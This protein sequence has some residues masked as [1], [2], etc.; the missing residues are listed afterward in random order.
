MGVIIRV[1]L[2]ATSLV[3][4]MLVQKYRNLARSLPAPPLSVTE[5]WGPGSAD[6]Y[7]EDPTVRPFD[8]KVDPEL[9][10][11]LRAQLSRPLRLQ[12]TLEGVGFEY[13]FNS[14]ALRNVTAYWRDTYLVNWDAREAYLKQFEH[15]ETQ[16][17]GLRV[18]FIHAKPQAT[19][20]KK[21]IPL[22]LLHGWPGSVRE[23]YDLIP[24]LTNPN[25]NSEYIFE[26]VAPS[27]SGYGWSQG[28]SKVGF[29]TAQ[30][31]VVLRNLMIR[32]GHNKFLL[33]GGDWG[34][35]VGTNMA[36]L[37]PQ[38]MLGYHSNSCLDFHPLAMIAK[39]IR[40]MFP[41]SLLND[42]ERGFVRNSTEE[43]TLILQESGY[44][45]IQAT[46]P[47]TIGA[48]LLNN[49]IGLAVYILEKFSSWTNAEFKKLP[50][51]GL[52][53]RYTMDALLDNVMIYY[54]TNS[55]TTSQRIYLE[56]I[57]STNVI[58]E[59]VHIKS[60]AGCARFKW[61]P[62]VTTDFEL[63][64][65]FKNLIHSTYHSNGGH[66]PALEI[67]Q[68]LYDDFIAFVKKINL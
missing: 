55:I 58:L 25:P 11:D 63:Q 61:D 29:G 49:P 42:E 7:K 59:R 38:N 2:V 56:I 15:F 22:L 34:A 44:F 4:A 60:P 16:I 46:K 3:L 48:A 23:F 17:Q 5:Y 24:L 18:H 20:G 35:T 1:L 9:I 64:F 43:I 65:K 51:G 39:T 53:K 26:V 52:T 12:E 27:L 45:N 32:L 54:I 14:E 40:T 30:I 47:D 31:A 41:N 10:A 68:T 19:E 67:P 62:I 28:A 57:S 6:N 13:G 21:V 66:F 36:A 33:Q 8:I 37:F 50:D